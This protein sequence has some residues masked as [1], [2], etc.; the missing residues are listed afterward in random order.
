MR[1]QQG[2]G[3]RRQS[4]N[5]EK[6]ISIRLSEDASHG[7]TAADCELAALRY[8]ELVDRAYRQGGFNM[9]E[10]ASLTMLSVTQV[11]RLIARGERQGKGETPQRLPRTCSTLL[12]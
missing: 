11:G 8:A 6:L 7:V 1:V 5:L 10:L 4:E 2:R 3:G 12:M 9:P